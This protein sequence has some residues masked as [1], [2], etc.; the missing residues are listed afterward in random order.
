MKPYKRFSVMYFC[1]AIFGIIL[2][3]GWLGK[4]YGDIQYQQGLLD[5]MPNRALIS[6]GMKEN[7]MII[8]TKSNMS[9]GL[10]CTS[11]NEKYKNY[12]LLE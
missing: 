1:F 8:R 12:T 4:E 2:I 10:Y 6:V 5:N 3:I 11:A 9:I 7:L